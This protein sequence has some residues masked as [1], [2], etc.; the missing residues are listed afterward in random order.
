MF[1][2]TKADNLS[3]FGA[4]TQGFVVPDEETLSHYCQIESWTA[5]LATGIFHLGATA[6]YH[7]DLPE[8]GDF[9]LFNLVQCYDAEDRHQVLELYEVAAMNPSSFCFSTTIIHQDGSHVPVMC[10]GE[11]SNFSDDG[12]GAING[13]F[14]FPKFRLN[15]QTQ[16]HT[17]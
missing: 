3:G 4:Q 10:I 16:S 17:Q 6:R 2:I 8:H 15:Q 12:S 9:G 5:N 1:K 11:S 13:V 14:V 7:H